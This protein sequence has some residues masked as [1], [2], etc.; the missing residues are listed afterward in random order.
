MM[1][2]SQRNRNGHSK[3]WFL[4]QGPGGRYCQCCDLSK[5]HNKQKRRTMRRIEKQKWSKEL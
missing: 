2:L 3:K 1:T 4:V 5:K